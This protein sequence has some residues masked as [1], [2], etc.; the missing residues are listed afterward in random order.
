M[1]NPLAASIATRSIE[2]LLASPWEQRIH[3]IESQLH[4]ELSQYKD[5]PEVSDVRVL[6]AIGVVETREPV[7]VEVAQRRFVEAGV[8]IRPFGTRVYL[9]PPYTID[10]EDLSALTA[11]IELSLRV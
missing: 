4:D 11:A 10:A 5:H 1:G 2:L 6:G 8:W 7:D 9:M 3:A